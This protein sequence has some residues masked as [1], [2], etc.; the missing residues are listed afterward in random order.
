M[1]DQLFG[2]VIL[3]FDKK[4]VFYGYFEEGLPVE[5][6][7]VLNDTRYTGTFDSKGNFLKGTFNYL[8]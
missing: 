8:N 3:I 6:T 4:G 7:L 2:P 5:G 1:N